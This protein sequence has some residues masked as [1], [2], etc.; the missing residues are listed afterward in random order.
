[1][2]QYIIISIIVAACIMYAAITV[3]KTWNKAK[4]CKEY[5]C[6]GC[7]FYEKCKENVKEKRNSATAN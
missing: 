7:P 2:T 1:M 4:N 3:Y 6:S 5:K